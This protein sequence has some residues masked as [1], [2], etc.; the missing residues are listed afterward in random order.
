MEIDNFVK[1][2]IFISNFEKHTVLHFSNIL[3]LA[4]LDKLHKLQLVTNSSQ[5]KF[6]SIPVAESLYVHGEIS[7]TKIKHRLKRYMA[8]KPQQTGIFITWSF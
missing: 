4:K 8:S 3:I 7:V 1:E 6:I 2:T 5:E